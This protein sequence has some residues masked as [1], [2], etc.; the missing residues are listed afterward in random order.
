MVL[1][2]IHDHQG[3]TDEEGQEL[4]G[5]AGNSYRSARDTLWKKKMIRDSGGCRKTRSGRRAVVWVVV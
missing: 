4:M 5:M 3:L 1:A 2:C